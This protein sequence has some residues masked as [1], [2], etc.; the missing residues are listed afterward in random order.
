[1]TSRWVVV[2]AAALAAATAAAGAPPDDRVAD[3]AAKAERLRG[4]TLTRPLDVRTLDRAKLGAELTRLLKA[5]PDPE[6][7]PAY[8]DLYHLLG[9]LKPDQHV[10]EILLSG[11]TDQIAGLYDNY[12]KRLLLISSGGAEATDGTVVH[13]IV[14]AI[15]DQRFNLSSRRFQPPPTE[16]DASRAAQALAEGDAL[17]TQTRFIAES[18]LSGAL[19]EFFGA[20]GQAGGGTGSS[21]PPYFQRSLVQPYLAGQA[22]V[23]ELRR[24]G[25]QR[26]VDKAFRAPPRT[27]AAVLDPARYLAGDPPPVAIKLAAAPR[28]WKRTISTT[29]GAADLSDLVGNADATQEWRGGRLALDANGRRRRLRITLAVKNPGPV[30]KALRAALPKRAV[31]SLALTKSARTTTPTTGVV[32]VIN[33]NKA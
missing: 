29:F 5:H 2:G 17:E 25:G 27:T 31:V 30:V 4:L 6:L 20:I 15:Q 22:F 21:L 8:D 1:M 18:G 13:E 33:G 3:L 7:G 16:R 10:R 24:R 12:T 23:S 32:V 11:L 19:G 9:V 14:H 26:L 28:G